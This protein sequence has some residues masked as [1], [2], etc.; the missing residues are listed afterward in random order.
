MD[1]PTSFNFQHEQNFYENG[2]KNRISEI[3]DQ[4]QGVEQAGFRKDYFI[5]DHIFTL[6]Q[7]IE[8]KSKKNQTQ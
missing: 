3:L 2:K 8:K 4:N 6:N 1:R 5:V 7:L